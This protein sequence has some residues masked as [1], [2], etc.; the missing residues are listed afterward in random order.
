VPL[1]RGT[2]T[3]WLSHLPGHGSDQQALGTGLGL[4]TF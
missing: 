2:G 4:A 3:L 1:D